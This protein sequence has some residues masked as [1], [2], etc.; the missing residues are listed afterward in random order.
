MDLSQYKSISIG[1]IAMKKIAIGGVT[2]W[3]RP[4]R[5]MVSESIGS[6]GNPFNG[7]LG[8]QDGLRLSSSGVTK[9]Y[10]ESTVTGYIPAK[11]GDVV[12]IVGVEW[13]SDSAN[14]I[15]AYDSSFNLLTEMHGAFAT[16]SKSVAFVASECAVLGTTDALIKIGEST[17]ST[18]A[19]N[20]AYIRVSSA[21]LAASR[22]D[23]VKQ[24][25]ANMIVTINEEVA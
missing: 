21:G 17:H 4:V 3:V 2:A 16:G 13:Y 14:Y 7:G 5:N 24:T 11:A 8:Y 18:A 23:G 6:D 15:C 19:A 22:N 25:G 20:T 12:R 9:E 1:G 10:A